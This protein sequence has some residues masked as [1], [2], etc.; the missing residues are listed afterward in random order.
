MLNLYFHEFHIV[1]FKCEWEYN[2]NNNAIKEIFN[3][4]ISKNSS[5]KNQK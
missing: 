2:V 5:G 3:F 4:I 1:L